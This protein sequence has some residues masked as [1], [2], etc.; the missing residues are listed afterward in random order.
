VSVTV[1]NPAPT[2]SIVVAANGATLSGNTYLDATAS[3]GTSNV[4]DEI[5]GNGLT[6]DVIDT[7]GLTV[8]GWLDSWNTSTVPNGTYTLQSVASTKAGLTGTSSPVTITVNNLTTA[9]VLPSAN[10]VL[11]GSTYLDATSSPP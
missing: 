7:A 6:N 8:Y 9:V 2:T 1:N 10:A 5:N 3:A 4:T 11:S